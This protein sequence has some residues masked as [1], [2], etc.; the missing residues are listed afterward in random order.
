VIDAAEKRQVIRRLEEAF[1]LADEID[2]GNTEFVIESALDEA[3]SRQFTSVG[4]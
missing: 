4:D 3:R 2:D 1:A